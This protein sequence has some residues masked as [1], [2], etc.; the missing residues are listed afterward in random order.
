M[1]GGGG[2]WV[3]RASHGAWC[4]GKGQAVWAGG[5]PRCW[6]HCT[7]S[8]RPAGHRESHNIWLPRGSLLSSDKSL[9]A[10]L[11]ADQLK[12]RR[13]ENQCALGQQHSLKSPGLCSPSTTAMRALCWRA[14]GVALSPPQRSSEPW[15]RHSWA[16]AAFREVK[17]C[18]C[19]LV[20]VPELVT[21]TVFR[22]SAC[23]QLWCHLPNVLMPRE[24]LIAFSHTLHKTMCLTDTGS[25]NV[26]NFCS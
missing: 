20:L 2:A 19:P 1:K 23:Q 18:F 8:A 15:I 13:N 3:S 5:C 14:R 11:I 10:G 7:P 4:G 26:Q 24:V 17:R 21:G 6:Q 9:P 16:S 22:E 12:S 25:K